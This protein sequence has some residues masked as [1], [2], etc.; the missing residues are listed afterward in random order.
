MTHPRTPQVLR[1]TTNLSTL[2]RQTAARRSQQIALVRGSTAWTWADLDARVDAL[3]TAYQD[4]GLRRGDV[5]MLHAPNSRQ[6]VQSAIAG[7][8]TLRRTSASPNCRTS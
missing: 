3:A 7:L 5:V 6:G 4:A 2:L 1:G 8:S